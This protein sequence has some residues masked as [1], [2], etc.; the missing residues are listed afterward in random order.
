L[1]DFG[2]AAT[3]LFFSSGRRFGRWFFP[4]GCTLLKVPART[5]VRARRCRSGPPDSAARHYAQKLKIKLFA[6]LVIYTVVFGCFAHRQLPISTACG[7]YSELIP[8]SA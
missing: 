8:V 5:A 7:L 4:Y 1:R 2:H 6:A 3:N